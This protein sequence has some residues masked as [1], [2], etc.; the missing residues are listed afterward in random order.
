MVVKVFFFS[1]SNA[2]Q[3]VSW[4]LLF[5]PAFLSLQAARRDRFAAFLPAITS[6]YF[7]A[8]DCRDGERSATVWGGSRD[9]V[10]VTVLVVVVK[11]SVTV[12]QCCVTWSG[13]LVFLTYYGV[14]VRWLTG[15]VNEGISL[16]CSLV[17]RVVGV[18]AMVRVSVPIVQCCVT[19]SKILAFLTHCTLAVLRWRMSYS[20]DGVYVVEFGVFGSSGDGDRCLCTWSFMVWR[21]VDEVVTCMWVWFS[22]V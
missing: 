10:V 18:V 16:W 2:A 22:V 5:L 1:F 13:I 17:R 4:W 6:N 11:V 19:W 20:D 9:G 12:V 15:S 14:V 8:A 7:P 3:F 21:V